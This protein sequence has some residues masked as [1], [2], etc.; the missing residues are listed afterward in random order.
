[1]RLLAYRR[2]NFAIVFVGDQQL[3]RHNNVLASM[4]TSLTS[5]KYSPRML[6][7]DCCFK[8]K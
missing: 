1:M 5:P 4:L 8:E 3:G 2:I 6:S 7:A